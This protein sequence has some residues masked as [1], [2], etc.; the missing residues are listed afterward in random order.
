MVADFPS[1]GDRACINFTARFRGRDPLTER[2]N[3][4]CITAQLEGYWR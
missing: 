1:R 4:R 3:E 2:I